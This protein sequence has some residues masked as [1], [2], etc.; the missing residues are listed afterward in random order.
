M[1][2]LDDLRDMM[3]ALLANHS[4]VTS[5][6]IQDN[7][8][9]FSVPFSDI[10]DDEKESLIKHLEA[11]FDVKMDLG[12]VLQEEFKPWLESAKVNIDPYFWDR[13]KKL[14]QKKG[15][16]LNVVPQIDKVTDKILG[17]LE[18]PSNEGAWER[19][20]LVVGHVQSGKTANYTGLV[21]KAA[22]AGYKLIIIIA[23]I[24]NNLRSQTQARLDEGFY[25]KDSS[26]LLNNNPASD[27]YIGVGKINHSKVP[28]TL[29]NTIKD[30]NKQTANTLGF[31]LATVNVPV[32]LVIKKNYNTLENLIAWLSEHN[33]S[34]GQKIE[35][36]PALVIDDE[37]DNASINTSANPD[38]ATRINGL[39]RRL[40]ELFHKRCCVGYTATPFANIFIDPN[41]NDEMF[42][43]DLFPRDFI[44]SLDPPTNYMGASAIFGN[45]TEN[46]II[47]NIDD[48]QDVIPMSHKKDFELQELP[49]SLYYA[50][51]AFV[52]I[53]AIRNLREHD[54]EHN[55]MLINISRFTNVQRQIRNIV[56]EFIEDLKKRI[57]YNYAKTVSD[58]LKDSGLLELHAVWEN[59]FADTEFTWEDLQCELNNAISPVKVIEVN[60]QSSD[61]LDYKSYS[62]DG[63][64]VIAVGGF[65]LSRGLTLEGLS[66]SYFYRNSIM[67]DTLMQMGRWFG[68]RPGYDDLCRIFMAPQAESWYSH[69]S[70]VTEELRDEFREMDLNNLTPRD[71]GLKVRSHPDSLIV[72]ARNKMQTGET[73]TRQISLERKLIETDRIN[74]SHDISTQNKQALYDLCNDMYQIKKPEKTKLENYLFTDI[75]VDLIKKFI[76]KFKNHAA[77]L[78]TDPTPVLEY[79]ERRSDNELSLWDVVIVNKAKAIQEHRERINQMDIGYQDR[80]AGEAAEI[81]GCYSIGEKLKVGSRGIEKEGL[82]ID[83]TKN[84]EAKYLETHPTITNVPD[85][86]YRDV[87]KK[88]LL[89]LHLL[90]IHKRKDPSTTLHN[91][92]LAYGIS[93]PRTSLE[94]ETVA[95]VVNT[96]W[97]NNMFISEADLED[98]D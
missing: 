67:Y 84:A 26:K 6:F 3:I 10:I 94:E 57:K 35:D 23:G 22:D 34:S 15:F 78:R 74:S 40:L 20:G 46:S 72:T 18:N 89:M 96:T 86:A 91:G 56:H 82:T 43:N 45:D 33:I 90:H 37:A 87:R 9:K 60:S 13:Y 64:D 92:A 85:K 52:L 30:F 69:I 66:V 36:F 41:T 83:E 5:E 80:Y 48:A 65:S 38:E 29:T 14:L 73:I 32:F 53:I 79:I 42:G 19:K 59:E 4:N 31:G 63:L 61:S 49:E 21:C 8:Q 17:L 88:P 1:G 12:A 71:F 11:Q 81:P 7:V 58:A 70:A 44:V 54:T 50:L 76:L 25:G 62:E 98:E 68:Y 28:V 97:W 24:H 27:K 51:R 2:Q 16:G 75:S 39:I 93:F 55:S 95:Y 77:S 47:R